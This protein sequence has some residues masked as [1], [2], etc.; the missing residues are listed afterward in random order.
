MA[1]I[2][3]NNLERDLRKF[4]GAA[5]VEL[6]KKPYQALRSSCENDWKANPEIAEATYCKWTGH[7]PEVS[8]E[9]YVSPQDSE[10]DVITGGAA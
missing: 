9:H 8:R 5:G 2:T 10:F 1:P 3:T 7:S 4:C 6:W